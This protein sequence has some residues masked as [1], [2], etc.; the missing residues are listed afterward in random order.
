MTFRLRFRHWLGARARRIRAYLNEVAVIGHEDS[1]AKRFHTFGHGSAIMAPQGVMYNTEHISIGEGVLVG[2]NVNLSAGIA[3]G[4]EMIDS[5]VVKIDARV[6]VGRGT[7]IVGHWD[8][9]IGEDV[10]IGPNVYITDQNHTYQDVNIPIGAQPGIESAVE[11]GPGSWI[12]ANAV[13]LPGTHLGK[14]TVVG[15]GA[16]VRGEFPDYAVI[17]GV[18]ARVIKVRLKTGEWQRI[19]EN[20]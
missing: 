17:A 18:P 15:A 11:I 13:I 10:I 3:I 14:N 19:G 9:N 1:E 7:S 8:I 5:P 12:A 2:P 16:V 20:R 6:V 4:Q